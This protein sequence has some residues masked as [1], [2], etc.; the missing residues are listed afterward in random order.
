[1]KALILSLFT[2]FLISCSSVDK[3]GKYKHFK[4]KSYK[5]NSELNYREIHYWVT[6]DNDQHCFDSNP[7]NKE[8]VTVDENHLNF[9][10]DHFYKRVAA[11]DIKVTERDGGKYMKLTYNE[12][13]NYKLEM[14]SCAFDRTNGLLRNDL[15]VRYVSFRLASNE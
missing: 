7:L 5:M 8:I 9:A 10:L 13:T 2:V 11:V 14:A 4:V 15:S 12:D 1:M 3:F 6:R